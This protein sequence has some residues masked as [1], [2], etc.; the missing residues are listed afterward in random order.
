[1]TDKKFVEIKSDIYKHNMQ[2]F[3]TIW[4]K[5]YKPNLSKL[6]KKGSTDFIKEAQYKITTFE[7]II[8]EYKKYLE[9][10]LLS[11]EDI[12]YLDKLHDLIDPNFYSDLYIKRYEEEIKLGRRGMAWA[13]A[14][15]FSLFILIMCFV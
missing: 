2:N 6:I 9:K 13:I 3:I 8:S 4:E 1:M 5:E 12:I 14:I 10:D 7:K 15:L 11:K